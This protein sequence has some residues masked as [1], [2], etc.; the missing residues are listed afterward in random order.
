MI[1]V[2]K[3]INNRSKMLKVEL[4]MLAVAA[5]ALHLGH[6]QTDDKYNATNYLSELQARQ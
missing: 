6:Q 1:L 5:R 3:N 2:I 4:I